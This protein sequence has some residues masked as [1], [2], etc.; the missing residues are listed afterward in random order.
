MH[1]G[2]MLSLKAHFI[3]SLPDLSPLSHTLVYLNLSF[4]D[5]KVF[6]STVL[7]LKQLVCLKMR[8]NPL[9]EIPNGTHHM[10]YTYVRTCTGLN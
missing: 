10:L 1:G 7:E 6:P 9:K 8:N 3:P 2:Y 4:N 5:L